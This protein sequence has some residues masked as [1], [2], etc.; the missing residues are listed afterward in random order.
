MNDR[1]IAKICLA[2]TIIGII[3]FAI[4]YEPEFK[5]KKISELGAKEGTQGIIFA[6]VEHVIKNSPTTQAIVT[7]G[8][9]AILYCSKQLDLNKNNFIKAY[10][11]S[12]KSDSNKQASLY[13]YKVEVE[14]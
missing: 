13:A 8:N 10:V 14:K 3:F 4:A 7:D 6:R 1:A 5:E 12:Q 2:I 11:I 9:R